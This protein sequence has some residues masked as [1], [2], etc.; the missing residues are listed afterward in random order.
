MNNCRLQFISNGNGWGGIKDLE[1]YT[2]LK[3]RRIRETFKEGLPFS[4]IEKK[5][6]ILVRFTDV[7][8]FL[9]KHRVQHD[10]NIFKHEVNNIVNKIMEKV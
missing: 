9:L 7:D 4:R 10:E 6:K 5:G 8:E 3:E 2:G 1:A